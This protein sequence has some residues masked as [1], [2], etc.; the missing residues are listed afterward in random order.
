MRNGSNRSGA[1]A[2]LCRGCG[3]R[4]V[5][6]PKAGPVPEATRQLVL[7][8]LGERMG[9]RAIA[10]VTGVSRSWL[11]GL[12]SDL[13]PGRLPVAGRTA[14]G[15]RPKQSREL[16]IEADELW[17]YVGSKR[18]VQWVWVALDAE[19]RRVVAMV[20]GDRSEFAAECVWLARPAE[21]RDGAAL[22][23]DVLP[24]YRAVIPE[25]RHA[26]AGKGAGLTAHVERSRL[27]ARQ[28]CGRLVRR[29]LSS[30]TCLENRRGAL[31]F[32]IHRYNP[33]R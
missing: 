1:P 21:Y 13:P 23:T 11:Q 27:T 14:A 4:F 30:A 3:R 33:S 24:A 20:T 7:R 17:S 18:Q 22:C 29:T 28:R 31:R 25:D 12:V 8:R 6:R 32:F 9:S 15:R 26:A 5:E 2:T 10:R 16:V 19:T